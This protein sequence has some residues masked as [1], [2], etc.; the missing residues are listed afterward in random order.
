MVVLDKLRSKA[1]RSGNRNLRRGSEA[2]E[3]M[4]T[5]PVLLLVIFAGFEYGWA[6]L[7][8]VQLDHAARLG[9]RQAALSGSTPES[10]ED[11]IRTSLNGLG[12]TSATIT[13][14][15]GDP[16]AADAGTSVTVEVQVDYANVQLLGLS[17]LMPLPQSLRGK[18]SMVREPDS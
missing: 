15:P 13:L 5:L 14:T 7:R 18:A 6:I 17:R 4:I 2:I 12:M 1:L 10:I 16:A 3:L 9:A 8:S 11:S